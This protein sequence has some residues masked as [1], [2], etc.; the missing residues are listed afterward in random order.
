MKV[1]RNPLFEAEDLSPLPRNKS[2]VKNSIIAVHLNTNKYI[3]LQF[4]RK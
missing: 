2:R 4:K 1:Q 3:G